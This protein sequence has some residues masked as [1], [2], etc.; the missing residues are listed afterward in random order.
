FQA[1]DSH[2]FLS[3][4]N[5]GTTTVQREIF[6]QPGA[7]TVAVDARLTPLATAVPIGSSGGTLTAG[8]ISVTVPA[9][10]VANGTTFQLTPLSAQG[11]PGLLPLGWSPLSAFDLRASAPAA[12]LPAAIAQLPNLGMHLAIYD[13]ALHAWTLVTPNLQSINGK[14]SFTV[15]APGAYALV[16]PDNTNPPITVP[17]P[18]SPLVGIA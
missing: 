16:V 17:D 18:G 5:T 3:A 11:L 6:V 13:S 1:S 7:G 10:S 9:G 15:P 12:G 8:A 4:A 2:L 14:C